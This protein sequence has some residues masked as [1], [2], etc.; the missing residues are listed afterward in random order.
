MMFFFLEGG[1][2]RDSGKLH[3]VGEV[4]PCQE[5]CHA[6][7]CSS[8]RPFLMCY[9]ALQDL[10]KDPCDKTGILSKTIMPS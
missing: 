2:V 10:L 9:M 4:A 5:G 7:D 3:T 8:R 1:Q 6:T